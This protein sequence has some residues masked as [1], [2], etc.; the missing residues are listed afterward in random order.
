ML[1][2]VSLRRN[3]PIERFLF[4]RHRGEGTTGAFEGTTKLLSLLLLLLVTVFKFFILGKEYLALH[5][6]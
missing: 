1:A 3:L 2:S 4:G 5:F 6:N